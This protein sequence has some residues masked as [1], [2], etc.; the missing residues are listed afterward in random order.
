MFEEQRRKFIV[1]RCNNS[2]KADRLYRSAKLSRKGA[3]GFKA[4]S[5]SKPDSV[6]YPAR[7]RFILI[8]PLY[9]LPTAKITSS[10][11]TSRVQARDLIHLGLPCSETLALHQSSQHD[12]VE[13]LCEL[14]ALR[15]SSSEGDC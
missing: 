3:R 10:T 9:A 8:F 6:S 5:P 4:F 15:R 12:P 7:H 11:R 2:N 13:A 14:S 1:R